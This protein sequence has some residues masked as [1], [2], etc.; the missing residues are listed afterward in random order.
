MIGLFAAWLSGVTKVKTKNGVI[1]LEN[2]SNDSEVYVGENSVIVSW[3]GGGKP[4]Q[5]EVP[6]SEHRINVTRGDEELLTEE[7]TIKSARKKTLTVCFESPD[8]LVNSRNE[9]SPSDADS[10]TG[11]DHDLT[12]LF[13]GRDLSGWAAFLNGRIVEPETIARISEGVRCPIPQRQGQGI[14]C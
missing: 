11:D 7:V 4:A 12:V 14:E 5:I 2:Y 8:A 13:N 9:P 3:P 10:V 1:V 6:P